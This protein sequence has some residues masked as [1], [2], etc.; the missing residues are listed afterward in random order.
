VQRLLRRKH[1]YPPA[2]PALLAA[3]DES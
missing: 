1:P 2:P 3:E